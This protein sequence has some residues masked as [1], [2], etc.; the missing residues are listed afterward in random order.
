MAKFL[1]KT[2]DQIFQDEQPA[3]HGFKLKLV[4]IEIELGFSQ[5]IRVVDL[6]KS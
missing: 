5:N 4:L 3:F 1:I 6:L 2:W